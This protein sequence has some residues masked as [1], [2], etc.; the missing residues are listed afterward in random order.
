MLTYETIRRIAH[1]ERESSG[2]TS[3]PESFFHDVKE[4]LDKKTEISKEKE[5]AWELENAK[6]VLK[7]IL[8]LREKK[9]LLAAFNFVSVGKTPENLTPEENEFFQ[10]VADCIKEFQKKRKEIMEGKE[11]K[12][13]VL[14]MLSDVPVFV[15]TDMKN[16]GPYKKG[17]IAN[18]PEDI[19]KLLIDKGLA[20]KIEIEEEK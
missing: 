11:E 19:A 9:I 2:L 17:D 16:Y 18:V 1:D 5:D 7:E 3:I 8:R 10:K 12:K 6:V 4:Y 13:T 15:G 20:R 14:A